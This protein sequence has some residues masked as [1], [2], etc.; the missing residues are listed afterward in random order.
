M[1][2]RSRG[3]S[4]SFDFDR[5]VAAARAIE[6][7]YQL[8]PIPGA[9]GT[10][11]WSIQVARSGVPTG[12]LGIPLRSMHS[13]VETVCLRDVERAAKLLVEL[14]TRLDQQFARSLEVTDAF[15]PAGGAT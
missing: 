15:A 8:E 10:D 3:V 6:L 14:I 12:L 2:L 7:P 4:S 1:F 9:S 5:L 11:A 13:P